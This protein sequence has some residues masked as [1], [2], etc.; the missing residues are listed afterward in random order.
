M[1]K[2]PTVLKSEREI[3]GVERPANVLPEIIYVYGTRVLL[4]YLLC[5]ILCVPPPGRLHPE[6]RSPLVVSPRETRITQITI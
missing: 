4:F 2:P 5:C 6:A 1:W 3:T